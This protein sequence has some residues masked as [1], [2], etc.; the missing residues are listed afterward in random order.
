MSFP[1]SM[2]FHHGSPC[3]HI[4]W[5]WTIGPVV[6]AVGWR[7]SRHRHDDDDDHHHHGPTFHF[8]KTCSSNDVGSHCCVTVFHDLGSCLVPWRNAT[9]RQIWLG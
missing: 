5:G 6:A 9:E 7:V 4:I 1:L 3:S 8:V 2:L